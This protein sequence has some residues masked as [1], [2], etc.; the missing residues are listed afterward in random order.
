MLFG[1]PEGAR[2]MELFML[3]FEYVVV[4]SRREEQLD[5]I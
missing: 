1:F 2:M 5:G 3:H 4:S